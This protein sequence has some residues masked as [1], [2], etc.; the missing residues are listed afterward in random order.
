MS[1]TDRDGNAV[2]PKIQPYTKSTMRVNSKS[3]PL[4]L[5]LDSTT[6]NFELAFGTVGMQKIG[7]TQVRQLLLTIKNAKGEALP[8]GSSVLD[9]K[10]NFI[11]SVVGD[12]NVMLTNSLIGA[13][14]RVRVANE[15]ECVVDY[16]VPKVFS[17]DALYE[18]A[19]A[20]CR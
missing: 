17:E 5:R 13:S 9:N 3:L 8:L 16:R 11:S 1:L 15:S 20:I 18:E 4:N 14:L 12:G 19:D 10:G 6:A 7:V 2:I